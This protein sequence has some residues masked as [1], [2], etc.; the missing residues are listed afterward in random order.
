MKLIGITGGV[1]AGKTQLLAY[2]REHYNC[3]IYLADQ[4]AH[5]VKRPG[6]ECYD[7]LVELMGSGILAPDGEID[8][9]AM[10]D[11]IFGDGEL[12][13]KVNEIVH[14]AVLAY[15]LDRIEKARRS[16]KIPLFFIEAALLIEA[17]YNSIVD[18]MWYVYASEETRGKRLM[19]SRGY[20]EQ[21]ISDIMKG[22]LEE[23]AFRE[24]SDFIIDNSGSLEEAY[25][26]ID[27]HLAVLLCQESLRK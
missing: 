12:L 13:K 11:R 8:K 27:E 1:G 24:K 19:Q 5:E 23:A 14:P 4:V 6:Q 15:L 16:R 7:S 21:K 3:E 9:K 2:I 22:Q 25:R 18:E 26:Q 17:G 10:A 20:T